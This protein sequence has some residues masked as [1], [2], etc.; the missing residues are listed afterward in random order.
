M[1]ASAVT[2]L[3]VLGFA[4][5]MV[6]GFDFGSFLTCIF[7]ALGFVPM[8]CAFA[9]FVGKE[10]KAPGYAAM[11]FAAVY[12]VLI[13]IVYFT[14]LTTV[15]LSLLSPQAAALLDYGNYGLMFNLD[16]LGY[17]FMA[18]ATFFIGLTIKAETKA[19]KWL[20]ALLLI[21]GVFAVTC[22]V[23]PML[24]IFAPGMT[25][26]DLIGTLVLEFW[27]A[28]FTPVCILA[29]VHFRRKRI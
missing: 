11:A 17:A 25:G 18:L 7:I 19:D 9:A 24:G 23:M 8:I 6:F 20:K 4:V 28:Y 26:G 12:A 14:Q 3:G 2:L 22:F 1:A 13:V 5:S 27:C 10:A 21:H 16:L 15:R 29:Y